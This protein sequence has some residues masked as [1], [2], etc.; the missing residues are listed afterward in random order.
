M[1]PPRMKTT[2]IAAL[3][4]LIAPLA[5]AEPSNEPPPPVPAQV[6]SAKTV[7]L[8][9]RSLD[10]GSMIAFAGNPPTVPF[11]RFYAALHSWGHFTMVDTPA[12][13]DL[14]LE[15]RV[16]AALLSAGQGLATYSMFLTLTVLDPKT[17]FV[18]WT[19]EAPLQSRL[20]QSVNSAVTQLL[21]S[22]DALLASGTAKVLK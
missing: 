20:E 22:F 13:A 10:A 8:S 11:E 17:H 21:H 7:F 2:C 1:M 15:F 9:N 3:V 12:E 6:L 19:I 5:Y 18:L 14:V 16:D 4:W